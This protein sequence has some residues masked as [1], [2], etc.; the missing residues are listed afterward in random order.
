[1][2]L[3]NRRKKSY[4]FFFIRFQNIRRQEK[5]LSVFKVRFHTCRGD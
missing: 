5:M 1:M 3:V 2:L 4:E